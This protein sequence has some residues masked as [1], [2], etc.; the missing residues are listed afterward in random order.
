MYDGSAWWSVNDLRPQ[1]EENVMGKIASAIVAVALAAGPLLLPL[2]ARAENGEITAGV[3]GG[4]IGGALLGRGC[5]AGR[6]PPRPAPKST[7]DADRFAVHET[8]I[9]HDGAGEREGRGLHEIA[10]DDEDADR[11][12]NKTGEDRTAA[13]HF[14][15]VIEHALL[16]QRRDGCGLDLTYLVGGETADALGRHQRR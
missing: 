4:L 1:L 13:H 11:A 12:E 16:R 14:Q 5:G 10:L 3:V 2:S 7:A 8:E 6:G 9:G 15:A